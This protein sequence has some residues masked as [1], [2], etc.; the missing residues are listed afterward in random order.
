MSGSRRQPPRTAPGTAGRHPSRPPNN[1]QQI[2]LNRTSEQTLRTAR[3]LGDAE[4]LA[5]IGS[6]E[7]DLRSGCTQWS[8]GLFRLLGMAPDDRERSDE[9]LLR[10]VH[11]DERERIARLFA[12]LA[13]RP[14]DLPAEGLTFELRMIR[15]DGAVCEVRARGRIDRDADGT[16]C[17]WLGFVQDVTDQ[18]ATERELQA[19]Y[20]VNQ[21]LREWECFEEGAVHLLR[22]LSTALGYPT[23]SLWLRDRRHGRLACRAFWSAPDVDAAGF[24]AATRARTFAPG[25]G[26]PG[27][28]WQREAP[29]AI[30]DLAADPAFAPRDAALESGLRS[31][32]AFPAVGPS[33]PIAVIS[34][35]RFEPGVPSDTM[36]RTLTALGG[37]LGRFL[38]RRRGHL[39]PSR[40]SPR[41]LEVLGLAAAGNTAPEIAE[42]LMVGRSTVKSHFENI[43][44]KLGVGDRAAAV[45]LALREG[46][47]E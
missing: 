34:L 8:A 37:E 16:P 28:A 4:V 36:V 22:R 40:L 23:A 3:L 39:E 5:R 44:D 27:L 7:T 25:D 15:P 21:A 17:R 9:E 41:E 1:V 20:A 13:E 14:G 45:A 35:Y 24:E 29:V 18:R 47:L 6:W 33:G 43:Y 2:P 10:F 38:D 30:A 31:A 11:E 19:H 32:V 42:R 26:K 12:S 46:L